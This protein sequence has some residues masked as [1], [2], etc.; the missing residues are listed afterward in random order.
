MRFA[1]FLSLA[2]LAACGDDTTDTDATETDT[3]DTTDTTPAIDGEALYGDNCA[4]CHG[5]TGTGGIGPNLTAEDNKDN[6]IDAIANG[7]DGMPGFSDDLTA[8]EIA[9]LAD[10]VISL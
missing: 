3:T 7:K 10:F 8:D 9:A 5:A 1:L 4:A 2:A 6:I